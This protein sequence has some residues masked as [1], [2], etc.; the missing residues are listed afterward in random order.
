VLADGFL[1]VDI[2]SFLPIMGSVSSMIVFLDSNLRQIIGV[3]NVLQ[4]TIV[5]ADGDHLTVNEYSY[6]D[7]FWALRGG[8]GG[9]YGILT[10]VTYRS[11]PN[12]SFIYVYLQV[13][14]TEPN[15][16]NPNATQNILAEFIRMTPDLNMQGYG[17]YSV[18]SRPFLFIALTSPNV[19]WAQANETFHPLFDYAISQAKTGG[20]TLVNYTTPYSSFEGLYTAFVA[21]ENGLGDSLVGT[22][23]EV[24]SWILPPS[25][26][27]NDPDSLASILID[28]PSGVLLCVP[29]IPLSHFVLWTVSSLSIASMPAEL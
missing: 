3:D 29:I 5:T 27:T 6:P 28:L 4:M 9:T 17:G 23:E 19:T 18:T 11:H 26:I 2:A 20:L 14:L 21:Q 25:T 13:Q 24:S 15:N 22:P 12:T 8:G 7:L 10:S 16:T 1:V